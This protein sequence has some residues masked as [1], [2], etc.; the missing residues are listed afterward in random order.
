MLGLAVLNHLLR[1]RADLRQALAKHAG[2]TI[3]LVVVPFSLSTTVTVDGQ[4]ESGDAPPAATLRIAPWLL[5]RLAIGDPTAER[6]ISIDGDTEL[7]AIFGRVLQALDWDAEADLAAVVGDTPAYRLSRAARD[8]VGDPRQIGRN[9][10]ETT[11]EYLQEEVRL[12][13]TQPAVD[14]FLQA[15]DT[16]RDDV[17]RLE[18]RL[19]QLDTG[20]HLSAIDARPDAVHR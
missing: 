19:S 1:Q 2:A 16:L 14:Q 11:R 3:K 10:L 12:L 4:L 6:E 15:V 17:A 20:A 13:A 8:L 7:A 5:P 9:L 18:K